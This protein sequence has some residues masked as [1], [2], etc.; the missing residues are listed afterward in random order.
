MGPGR[1]SPS[2]GPPGGCGG[3]FAPTRS[4]RRLLLAALLPTVRAAA[5]QFVA[6][7][8]LPSFPQK[9]ESAP[10]D[11]MSESALG[12]NAAN[13]DSANTRK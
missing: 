10:S 13:P 6:R 11:Y 8:P 7:Q 1:L 4:L 12:N 5:P 9:R 3:S 2:R